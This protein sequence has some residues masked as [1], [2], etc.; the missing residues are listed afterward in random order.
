MEIQSG[1]CR[2]FLRKYIFYNR[3]TK[4]IE[5][6]VTLILTGAKEAIKTVT[7]S[8]VNGMAIENYK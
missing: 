6:T 5:K 3:Q 2:I 4:L 1:S 7:I 8:F